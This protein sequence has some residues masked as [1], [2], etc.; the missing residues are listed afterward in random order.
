MFSPEGESEKLCKNW[1]TDGSYCKNFQIA[2]TFESVIIDDVS[3]KNVDN[4]SIPC[5]GLEQEM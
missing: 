2:K 1:Q 5:N 4:F 3:M